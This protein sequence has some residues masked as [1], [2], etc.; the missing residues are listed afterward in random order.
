MSIYDEAIVDAQKLREVAESAAKQKVLE[1]ITPKIRELI[2]AR[3]L[4]EQEGLDQDEEE[5]ETD[6]DSGMDVLTDEL[7]VVSPTPATS[8]PDS[9]SKEKSAPVVIH[10]TGDIHIEAETD[11][12]DEE[13][14]S[15]VLTDQ[16]AEG[17]ARMIKG[18]RRIL[19]TKKKIDN[20]K[21]TYQLFKEAVVR[22]STKKN[23][24]VGQK[25]KVRDTYRKLAQEA[26]SLRSEV[27]VL[28]GGSQHLEGKLVDTI[29][30]M[31]TMSSKTKRNIFDFLFEGDDG[32]M[33][34]K[35]SMEE[36]ELSLA[37]DDDEKSE[38]AGKEEDEIDDALKSVLGDV[39][40]DIDDIDDEGDEPA[41]DEDADD[42]EEE[43]AE[44]DTLDLGEAD[45]GMEETV[46]EIDESSLRR[47]L[48]KMKRLRESRNTRTRTLR[49]SAADKAD[50]FGDG[51]V[52]GDV[53]YDIDEDSL[54]NVLADELG[55][56]SAGGMKESRRVNSATSKALKE[57][58]Q[59]KKAAEALKGQLVEMNLFNAKLL[60]ANKLMQ[61][62]ELTVKQQRAIVEAL[63]NA[64]T[65][66]EA[67]LLY[68]SLSE[69]LARR[70]QK[71]GSLSENV[72]RT[73]LGSSSRS[74]RS[75][76]PASSGVEVDRWAVLAGIR[77]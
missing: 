55:S 42:E 18:E 11:D 14:D 37:L 24:T 43:G 32:K 59:Y 72:N 54:I 52:L 35:H 26:I 41:E 4:N 69:S 5:E 2:N 36:A 25:R 9:R 6:S 45:E 39:T 67:K 7:P 65:L 61:N 57:A 66:Q 8:P 12:D 10:N 20:L 73:V 58:A 44:E 40:F 16:M 50:Q 13:Q 63:D 76:Q 38:L 64:K 49:E 22:L 21:K 74:T 19:E 3:I 60:Y 77:E 30:E 27:K 17:L 68:K 53:F 1:A 51:E 31:R 48:G 62:K 56:V 28:G 29:K 46:Y 34:G 47:E 70:A 33:E 71:S 23:I 75:A 15:F